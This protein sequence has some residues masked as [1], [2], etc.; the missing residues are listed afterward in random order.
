M[1]KELKD[2]NFVKTAY[3]KGGSK[4][5]QKF[6]ARHKKYP[7]Q[8]LE[9]RI[10]GT[11]TIKYTIDFHGNVIKTK[12]VSGLGH[13]CDQEAERVVKLLKF[14]V[15]P[16]RKVKVQYHR[17]VHIHFRL[18]VKKSKKIS[19]NYTTTSKKTENTSDKSY[20]YKINFESTPKSP[21]N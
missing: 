15:P 2:K 21:Q 8:A 3:Y 20:S 17:T 4:A 19:Y 1:K 5:M 14:E 9:N 16:S 10:E 6:I 12:V 7:Q 13:G 11:V 18:P